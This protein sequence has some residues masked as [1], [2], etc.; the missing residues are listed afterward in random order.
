MSLTVLQKESAVASEIKPITKYLLND[1]DFCRITR[2]LVQSNSKL[3]GSTHTRMVY[4]ESCTTHTFDATG[5]NRYNAV[6]FDQHR[7][8]QLLYENS[9]THFENKMVH[10]KKDT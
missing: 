6:F 3:I 4:L 10:L 7:T 5:R 1:D 2:A 8:R 9:H